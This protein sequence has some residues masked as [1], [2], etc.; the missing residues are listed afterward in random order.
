MPSVVVAVSASA[1]T[2]S[3]TTHTSIFFFF[4]FERRGGAAVGIV[5]AENDLAVV[6]H[7]GL[8]GTWDGA[9]TDCAWS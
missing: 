2:C 1:S 9:S 4:F 6:E 7:V 5:M 8:E 3:E